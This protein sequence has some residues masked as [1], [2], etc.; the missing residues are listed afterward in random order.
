[1]GGLFLIKEVKNLLLEKRALDLLS[2]CFV[3]PN[4][5]QK[6][7]EKI[8]LFSQNKAC[9]SYGSFINSQLVGILILENLQSKHIIQTIAIDPT[10]ERQNIASSLLKAARSEYPADTFIAETDQESLGFYQKSG[11]TVFSL[12][13]KYPGVLRFLCTLNE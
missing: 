13:E 8:T 1:V 2:R 12:G 10:L 7:I 9:Q 11:F 4:E 3:Y 5:P 6:L